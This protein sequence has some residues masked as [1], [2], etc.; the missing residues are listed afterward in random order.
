MTTAALRVLGLAALL[1]SGCET[2]PAPLIPST[3][4]SPAIAP[5]DGGVA[6]HDAAMA[7]RRL[8]EPALNAPAGSL[9]AFFSSLAAAETSS[10]DGRVLISIFGDSHTA[11]DRFTGELRHQLQARFGDGGRGLVGAGRPPMKYYELTDVVSG[12]TGKWKVSIGGKHDGVEPFGLLGFR[13]DGSHDAESWVGTETGG[14]VG[15]FELF[16]LQQ[17]DG[18]ELR[19]SVD[20]GVWTKLSTK[21]NTVSPMLQSIPVNEGPHRLSLRASGKKTVSLFGVAMERNHGGVIIDGMGV[22]GRTLSQ[23]RSWDWSVIGAQLAMRNPRLVVLQYGTNEVDDKDLDLAHLENNYVEMIERIRA[24]VPA[25][26][27]LVLGPPDRSVRDG[28]KRFCE[29]QEKVT[30]TPSAECTWHTPDRLRD[31]VAAE[32]HAAARA[33]VAFFNTFSAFGGGDVMSSFVEG[34][35]KL[36]YADHVHFTAAG[37]TRWA[38]LLLGELDVSYQ[39]WRAS[40]GLPT[41]P[42]R[43]FAPPPGT[44]PPPVSTR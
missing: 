3:M 9:D 1:G 27:I 14:T 28:H 16:Y 18:G 4:P 21:A 12:A 35:A 6:S 25:A 5:V 29:R 7:R 20:G 23:L 44:P 37:Y 15:K 30:L 17:P 36:A 26:S 41:E 11:G 22:I 43:F 10:A 34:D 19:Y 8:A 24:T 32:E 38:D 31:I 13:V 33:H 42:P 39:D 40:K 2:A